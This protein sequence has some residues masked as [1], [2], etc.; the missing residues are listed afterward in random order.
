MSTSKN[1]SS[2]QSLQ[3]SSNPHPSSFESSS[4]SSI[5]G[6]SS[7][8]SKL[9]LFSSSTTISA[10]LFLL[11]TGNFIPGFGTCGVTALR[12]RLLPLLVRVSS[13]PCSFQASTSPCPPN[14]LNP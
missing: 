1:L 6:H 5:P 3:S 2:Q 7:V 10:T 14:P 4:Q 11:L 9:F 13:N 12:C 8:S